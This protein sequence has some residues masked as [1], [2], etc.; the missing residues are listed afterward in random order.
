MCS[1]TCHNG[2]MIAAW[3]DFRL[4]AIRHDITSS[5]PGIRTKSL[6]TSELQPVLCTLFDEWIDKG[7]KPLVLEPRDLGNSLA[8]KKTDFP[9]GAA[10]RDMR[11]ALVHGINDERGRHDCLYVLLNANGVHSDLS[12]SAMQTLLP[13]LDT[14]L[15]QV[16]LLPHQSA[17]SCTTDILPLTAYGSEELGSRLSDREIEIMNWVRQGKTNSEIGQILVISTSTVKNHL[18]RIFKKL[19]VVNRAQAVATLERSAKSDR[20]PGIQ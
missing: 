17:G 11:S 3:G 13:Y 16:A 10:F 7:R 12:R 14:A 4:G 15:R 9:I 6:D 5:V 18:Q 2:I 1:T 8:G 20:L 19:G